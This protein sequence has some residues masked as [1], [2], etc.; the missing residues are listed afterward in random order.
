MHFS[1]RETHRLRMKEWRYTFQASGKHREAEVAILIADRID[2]K[3]GKK[4]QRM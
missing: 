1:L 4:K 2:F 3:N